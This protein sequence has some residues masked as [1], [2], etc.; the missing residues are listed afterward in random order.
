MVLQNDSCRTQ[1][2]CNEN[3]YAQPAYRVIS[4]QGTESDQSA[5]YGACACHVFA[6]F[7][8][9]V[10]NDTDNHHDKG[11]KDNPRH[12]PWDI[13]PVHHEQAE[14]VGSN[15]KDEGDVPSFPFRQIFGTESVYLAEQE[16]GQGR[17]KY[18]EAI[19]HAQ[20]NQLVLKGHDAQV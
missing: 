13:Q 18:G 15:G 14:H 10:D 17:H 8:F 7:P 5:Y 12:I 11:G 19:H 20:Y 1:Y 4:E 6:E 3:E 9:Q 2:A 16:N